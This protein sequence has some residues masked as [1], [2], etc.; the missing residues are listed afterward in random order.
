MVGGIMGQTLRVNLSDRTFVVE[1][2][3]KKYLK[4]YL[5]GDGLG[6]KILYD[7][8]PS[9]VGALEPNN[10]LVVAAGPLCGTP[11]QAACTH[12]F[13]TKCP[14]TGFTMITSR[15]NGYFGPRLKFSG[16]D[17]IV[18]EGASSAPV[19]LYIDDGTPR[20]IDASDIWGKGVR[21]TQTMITQ[22]LGNK[23]ISTDCI[24]PA[25]EN[26]VQ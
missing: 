26:Q 21:E 11:V 15:C 5:G 25:G 3:S 17:A 22:R 23:D 12:S 24:G 2:L 4:D 9:G 20:F 8:V 6:S 13:I 16:Y 19:I 1:D 7:E 10:R 14:I 18:I